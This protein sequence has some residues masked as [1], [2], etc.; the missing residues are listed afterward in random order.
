MGH[1]EDRRAGLSLEL[2]DLEAHFLAEVGVE[3]REGLVQE[4]DRGIGHQ[5]ARQ[6][7][8]LLLS[9]RQLVGIAIREAPESDLF[10]GIP[11]V[12]GDFLLRHFGY[13]EGIGDVFVD[14]F[15]GPHRVVLEDDT[16]V[17]LLRRKGMFRVGRPLAADAHGSLV[18]RFKARDEPEND[19]L[20]AAGRAEEGKAFS[21]S[22]G[23]VETVEHLS[24]AVGFRHS[25]Q[26]KISHA[27]F[28]LCER[29]AA[30][31]EVLLAAFSC[32]TWGGSRKFFSFRPPERTYFFC[33]MAVNLSMV[34]CFSTMSLR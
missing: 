26:L 19:R 22:Y 9:S 12:L 23:E 7:D 18:R 11:H 8:P 4:H 13:F 1:V 10:D 16:Y 14:S 5:G 17:P 3:V 25:R 2:L 21:R 34:A 29:D 28:S 24:G 27:G 20:S 30:G 32:R 31:M 33:I 6:G 15:V